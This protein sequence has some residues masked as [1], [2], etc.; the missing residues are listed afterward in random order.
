MDGRK[1]GLQSE[2]LPAPFPFD[3]AAALQWSSL[4]EAEHVDLVSLLGLCIFNIQE[5][6]RVTVLGTITLCKN[7]AGSIECSIVGVCLFLGSADFIRKL[8]LQLH[9][10]LLP[11]FYVKY[12]LL[13]TLAFLSAWA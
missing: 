2:K 7:V 13:S 5:F 4:V 11:L 1:G 12:Y 6:S 9:W 8:L 3:A 10:C